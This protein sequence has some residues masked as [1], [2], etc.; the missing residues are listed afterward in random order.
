MTTHFRNNRGPSRPFSGF[1]GK[2]ASSAS[3]QSK[4]SGGSS[5]FRGGVRGGHGGRGGR[6]RGPRA[7]YVN[8]AKYINKVT[9]TEEAAVFKPEHAFADFAIDERLKQT[10]VGKGYISPTPIQDRTIPHI[11]KG[12]DLVGIANTGTGKTAAFLIPLIHKVILKSTEKVLIIVPTRELALQIDQEFK[13][14]SKGMKLFS[15]CCVGGMP[16][17]RQISML[18]YQNNFVIG[19]P[20][21][22][23][24]LIERGFIKPAT[25]R[26]IV[27]DEADRMLDMGFINDMRFIMQLMPKDRHTLFFSATL[28]PEIEKLIGTFLHEPVRIS[29]K[30]SDTSKNVEQDVVRVTSGKTKLDVLNDLLK[31]KEFSKVL[32]FG[33]TKHGVEKLSN[34]LIQKGFKAESIHG[35]KNHS[36]RQQALRMFKEGN[37]QI[38]VATDVAARGLDI[39]DITHVINYELPMTYDDYVHRIGRTGRGSKK[40]KAL[41]FID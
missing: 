31:Q 18:R 41:T 3:T 15:V 36:K 10:I 8:P 24:D 38:L 6:G 20:G 32:I 39:A 34:I 26:T 5:H 16:I 28:S 40:G 23:K 7:Q 19:T 13:A 17:G 4:S 27:L 37:V 25:F 11:L 21:R 14:F 35:N 12:S 33:Q 1:K 22:L 29:V 2:P 9:V 30:T